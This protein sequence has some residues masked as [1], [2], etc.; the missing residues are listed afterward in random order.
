MPGMGG[1][2]VIHIL[3]EGKQ[4]VSTLKGCILQPQSE[5]QKVREYLVEHGFRF[6]AE[7]MVEEDGK[8]YPMMRVVPPEYCEHKTA[9]R[10]EDCK[11]EEWEYLYG[12][13]LLKNKNPILYEYLKREIRIREDILLGLAGKDGER[14]KERM[15]EIEHELEV[16]KKAMSY[17]EE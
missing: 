4:I 14:I 10:Q 13:L 6:E 15:T 11:K 8:Y 12:P 1:G 9:D 3:E 16:A 5:I 17:Y 7:D 2:L